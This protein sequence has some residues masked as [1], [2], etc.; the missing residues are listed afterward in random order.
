VQSW[1]GPDPVSHSDAKRDTY[2]NCDYLSYGNPN[3]ERLPRRW[4]YTLTNPAHHG[5]PNAK[6]NANRDTASNSHGYT[7]TNRDAFGGTGPG[8]EYLDPTAR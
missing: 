5:Y 7:Y 3:A 6:S 4:V 8:L 2:G 1:A